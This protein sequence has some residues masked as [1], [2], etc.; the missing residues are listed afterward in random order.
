MGGGGN[1]QVVGSVDGGGEE[2]ALAVG[3]GLGGK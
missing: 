1:G 2:R 3:A